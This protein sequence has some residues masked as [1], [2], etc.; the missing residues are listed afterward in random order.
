M[1]RFPEIIKQA[2]IV[3]F[4]AAVTPSLAQK[5]K[6]AYSVAELQN[7]INNSTS[8][9]TLILADGTYLN[10]SLTISKD[11]IIVMA[12]SPGG[13]FLNGTQSIYITGDYVTFSGFQFTS[14]DI[15]EDYLIKVYGSH[16]LLTQLNISGYSAKK[17]IHIT[18]GTQYNEITYCNIENK[19]VDAVI[20][21]T[22]QISTHYSVPGYHK[23]RYCSFRNFPGPGGDYG[24]EPIRI[25]LSTERDNNSRT[26]VEYCYFNNVGPGDSESISVKSC[27]NICRY[28]TF[29]NNPKGMLVFR[30]GDRNIAYSNFFINGSGGIRI[31][32]S[33]DSYCY[34][35]Y[36]ET[37][38]A[39]RVI[40]QYD[41]V[42]PLNN[43]NFIHNT[44]VNS[45][46]IDLGKP[47]PTNVTFANNI[48]KKSSGSIFKDA[49][50][51]ETWIE[52]IY[53]GS[54]GI[55]S[56]SGLVNKDPLLEINSDGYYGLSESSPAIDAAT[57]IY[58]PIIHILGID[59]DPFIKQ[60]IRGQ[61]RLK[62][63]ALKDIGCDEFTTG[64][65]T[66]RPLD[67]SDVGP[68]YLGGPAYIK[69][70]QIIEFAG[71]PDKV[72]GDTDFDPEAVAS[73][74]LPV[75]YE[76][77]DTAVAIIVDGKLHIVNAGITFITASQ[78]GNDKYKAASDISQKLLVNWPTGAQKIGLRKGDLIVYPNPATTHINFRSDSEFSGTTFSIISVQGKLIK[79]GRI[80]TNRQH[81]DISELPSGTFILLLEQKRRYG[82]FEKL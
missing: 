7:N 14:G 18:D 77:S 25:G 16:N 58:P 28:N 42:C 20:G 41:C 10:T 31:K 76:S 27:E 53:Y 44:F 81:I 55:S 26:I 46:K 66:N 12:Q 19:P 67:L 59:T 17:Y 72:I 52:N 56:A 49:T 60:D 40:L 54:L 34:N 57:E 68:S 30:N 82:I 74:G 5:T 32:E 61:S 23:I 6:M 35:N 80:D 4:I 15:G 39:Y 47:G 38:V 3:V 11:R 64:A 29:T 78:S 2:I 51:T 43:A 69:Q 36:F 13:V 45:E 75:I 8:G 9:D 71:L 37:G 50:G 62:S 79:K 48:F 1:D 21:C 73:S 33:K 65:I 63:N 22:I 70:N 24:N